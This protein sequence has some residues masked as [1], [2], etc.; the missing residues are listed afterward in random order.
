MKRRRIIHRG[1]S[2]RRCSESHPRAALT[3]DDVRLMR[4]LHDQGVGYRTIG[5]KFECSPWTARDIC[6]Y[7]TR[8][9]D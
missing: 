6:T 1:P 2:G 9:F 3:R 5:E 8:I 4:E 7:R